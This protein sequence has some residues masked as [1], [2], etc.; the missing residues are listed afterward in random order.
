MHTDLGISH[1]IPRDWV[2]GRSSVHLTTLSVKG[3]TGLYVQS[4]HREWGPPCCSRDVPLS[5]M[6][7]DALDGAGAGQAQEQG[8]RERCS[9]GTGP[10]EKAELG[11]SPGP[12]TSGGLPGRGRE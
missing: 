9:V 11:T 10:A 6:P 2:T 7:P 5:R 12:G 4:G 8:P 1:P 3:D